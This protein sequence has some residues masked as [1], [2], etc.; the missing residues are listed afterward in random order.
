MN[1]E[2]NISIDYFQEYQPLYDADGE[3]IANYFTSRTDGVPLGTFYFFHGY[4]GSPVEP[5]LLDVIKIALE[6]GFNTDVIESVKLSATA[7][8][9]KDVKEMTLDNH[10]IALRAGLKYASRRPDNLGARISFSHS[11]GAH[12]LI[13][14]IVESDSVRRF[15]SDH[16]FIN[17][18]IL[19]QMDLHTQRERLKEKKLWDK[20]RP[21]IR[22]IAGQNWVIPRSMKSLHIGLP[23]NK[24]W[25]NINIADISKIVRKTTMPLLKCKQNVTFIL[26]ENDDLAERITNQMIYEFMPIKSKYLHLIDG[27]D[28]WMGTDA[29]KLNR[30]T[31]ANYLNTV[32]DEI[33]FLR[34]ELSRK[35]GGK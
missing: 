8:N 2:Y 23:K 20:D 15:F 3:H 21:M 25:K 22:A 17:P 5:L 16:Y 24:H 33:W 29:R 26:G 32:R 13:R 18:Y 7:P 19:P 35:R 28:H 30:V 4:G 14:L 27:A 12:A 31:Y 9:P 6:N 1:D 11:L 34:D 10:K